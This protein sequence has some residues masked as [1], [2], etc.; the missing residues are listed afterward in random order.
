MVQ[1]NRLK[2]SLKK[3][4]SGLLETQVVAFIIFIAISVANTQRNHIHRRVQQASHWGIW[5]WYLE[6]ARYPDSDLYRARVQWHKYPDV[7]HI[8]LAQNVATCEATP[9]R[10]DPMCR[11]VIAFGL[12]KSLGR[13]GLSRSRTVNSVCMSSAEMHVRSIAKRGLRH[14]I[15]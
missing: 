4:R 11:I 8:I 1:L 15:G 13:D 6:D 12:V 5:Q 7:G 2:T 10:F 9:W 3:R 14:A